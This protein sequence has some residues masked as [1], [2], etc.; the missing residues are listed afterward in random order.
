MELNNK[1]KASPL[2]IITRV[3]S[4]ALAWRVQVDQMPDAR[5][6]GSIH[7]PCK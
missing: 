4:R 2:T 6:Y 1:K 5:M 3:F 7:S